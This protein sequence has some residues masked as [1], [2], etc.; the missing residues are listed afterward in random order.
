MTDR[1]RKN[2]LHEHRK[3]FPILPKSINDIRD[4]INELQT[5][6]DIDYDFFTR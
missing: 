4:A 6:T 3:N 2:I 1:I 5:K